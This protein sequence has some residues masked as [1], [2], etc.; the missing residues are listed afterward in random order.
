[1]SYSRGEKIEWRHW[2]PIVGQSQFYLCL[3]SCTTCRNDY[4]AE[5]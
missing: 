3:V 2:I 1:M 5:S 4:C